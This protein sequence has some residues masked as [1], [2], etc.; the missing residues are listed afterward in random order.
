MTRPPATIL[1]VDDERKS[2]RLLEALLLPEGYLTQSAASGEEALTLIAQRAPDLILLDVMMPGMNGYEVASVLKANPAVSNIPIIMLTALTDRGARLAGLEA[3]AE[4]F[5]T[6]PVD[7]AELWLRVRN[8]LRLKEF[9][10]FL[11]NHG[12]ILEEQVQARTSQLQAAN[13]ELLAFSYAVSH[14]LRT[15][16]STIAGFSGLLDKEAD[17]DNASAR[18]KHYIARIRAGVVQ[19]SELIDSLLSLAHVSRTSLRWDRVDLSTLAQTILDSYQEREPGRVVQL[20]IQPELVVQGDP[21]LLRNVLDNLLGNAWKFSS[22]Q[23]LTR[24]AFRQEN[25][26]DGQVVYVVQDTGAGFDMAYSDKLFG[27]FQRLHTAAEF[28]G[29]GI[30]LATVHRIVMRHGGKVWADSAPGCGAT[31]YFTLLGD[32]LLENV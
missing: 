3:G 30:G 8:L 2:R 4:D 23:P 10:D 22:Q 5:L 6:K 7:R 20:D 9:G 16:L 17:A 14:D 25:G 21:T 13:E 26:A 31:F 1:I 15:P 32:R 19:M 28:A 27:A 29:S 18:S 11:Q 12:R 24:I